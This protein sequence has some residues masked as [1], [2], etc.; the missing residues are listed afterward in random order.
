M[1]VAVGNNYLPEWSEADLA[2]VA[3][4]LRAGDG[5]RTIA[6]AMDVTRATV[7][8]RVQR[9][10]A[11]KE[12]GFKTMNGQAIRK[13]NALTNYYAEPAAPRI[14]KA[15]AEPQHFNEP[16]LG[17]TIGITDLM[18]LKDRHCKFPIGDPLAA[19]FGFCGKRR[20]PPYSY[21]D[22]HRRRAYQCREVA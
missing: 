5:A 11:L 6:A 12:I 8:G 16:V 10:P 9:R 7:I 1:T 18:D 21:C 19:D 4:M 15:K 14:K 17:D 2:K 13:K 3:N 22:P 20:L